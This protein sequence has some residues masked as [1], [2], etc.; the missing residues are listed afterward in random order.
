MFY[1]DTVQDTR[2]WFFSSWEKY[3]HKKPLL[4]LEQQLIEVILQHPEYHAML[5]KQDLHAQ[6][7][8]EFGNTN[9][10]LHMGL[11]LTI[12]DQVT[13]D[14]PVG[15]KALF[16]RLLDHDGDAH[17]VVHRLLEPLADCIWTAQREQRQPDEAA[18]LLACQQLIPL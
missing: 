4:P 12:R 13:M 5:S 11:H 7:L 3:N 1:G 18:Y 17:K 16:Q 9:P 6:Y 10:F 8:P 14:R 15:M 2:A